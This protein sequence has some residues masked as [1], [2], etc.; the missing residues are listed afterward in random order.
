MADR[1]TFNICIPLTDAT[2]GV[3]HAP[4]KLDEWLLKTAGLFGGASVMGVAL[5]GLWYDEDR[6]PE[7]N[8]VEDHS[9]WYK[10]GVKPDQVDRLRRHVEE[11][12]VEFGQQCLYLERAGEADFIWNPGR[13]PPAR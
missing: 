8:P 13:R 3:V 9:N 11:A 10:I 2:T 1:V 12:A 5:L 7:E 4:E 6:A